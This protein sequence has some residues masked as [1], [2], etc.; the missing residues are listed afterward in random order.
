MFSICRLKG[1]RFYLFRRL[2]IGKGFYSKPSA[3]KT[4]ATIAVL[5]GQ[6]IHTRPQV[7]AYRTAIFE[8][9]GGQ[10]KVR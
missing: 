7:T 9:V 3:I 2:T 8:W 1:F 4:S 5:I 6:L 10:D